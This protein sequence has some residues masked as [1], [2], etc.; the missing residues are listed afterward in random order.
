MMK[1]KKKRIKLNY[2]NN[3]QDH[4]NNRNHISEKNEFNWIS[5]DNLLVIQS[6]KNKIFEIREKIISFIN[7]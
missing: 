4:L 2:P 7:N 6:E 5:K 3:Y 1:Y